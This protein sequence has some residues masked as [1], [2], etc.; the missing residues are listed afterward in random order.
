M[1]N[2]RPRWINSHTFFKVVL[3]FQKK[4]NLTTENNANRQTG[5]VP[6]DPTLLN[7]RTEGKRIGR[8]CRLAPEK[9]PPS[10]PGPTGSPAPA[11]ALASGVTSARLP[12]QK[13]AA[14]SNVRWLTR[15]RPG[16]CWA[17]GG[18][19]SRGF[20]WSFQK[21]ARSA[22]CKGSGCP[23]SDLV[24]VAGGGRRSD[25]RGMER[26]GNLGSGSRRFSE[27]GTLEFGVALAHP[28]RAPG[29]P[30]PPCLLL[31]PASALAP[32]LLAS[33]TG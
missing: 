21:R 33:L 28:G 12:P 1:L 25:P 30:L 2:S 8:P 6:R 9:E 27:P 22:R 26:S 20:A 14:L 29:F 17:E 18:R 3:K 10:S 19:E 31:T 13:M 7:R 5:C 4:L 32:S 16:T 24:S 15:V 11:V 23:G